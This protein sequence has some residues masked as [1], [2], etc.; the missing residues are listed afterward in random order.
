MRFPR[1]ISLWDVMFLLHYFLMRFHAYLQH[2]FLVRLPS[3]EFSYFCMLSCR[4]VRRPYEICRVLLLTFLMRSF[5]E[6]SWFFWM[7]WWDSML[8]L[9]AD[10]FVLMV[11]CK[12]GWSGGCW[13]MRE[14]EGTRWLIG[15]C[16]VLCVHVW[17]FVGWRGMNV[18]GVVVG[19]STSALGDGRV[20]VEVVW[21]VWPACA[22]SSRYVCLRMTSRDVNTVLWWKEVHSEGLWGRWSDEC[23]LKNVR[24]LWAVWVFRSGLFL[25]LSFHAR[26][27]WM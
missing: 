6:M 26:W 19:E 22:A 13:R 20:C 5:C 8:M 11:G 21:F 12:G 2:S 16:V 7:L 14:I 10:F 27:L 15:R 23:N 25:L 24:V 3:Y 9:A 17:W 18:S 1:E 4:C